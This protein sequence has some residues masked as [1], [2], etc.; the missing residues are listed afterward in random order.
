MELVSYE[1]IILTGML[2]LS[3]ISLYRV[4]RKYRK[5]NREQNP[6]IVSGVT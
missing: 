5:E 6:T 4:I 3:G 2:I 1:N